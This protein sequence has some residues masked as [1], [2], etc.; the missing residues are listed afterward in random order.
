M[1]SSLLDTATTLVAIL[2]AENTALAALDLSR[3]AQL[4]GAKPEAT[5][6]FTIAHARLS[7]AGPPDDAARNALVPLATQLS[8]LATENHRL[9]DRA[10]DTQRR[11]LDIIAGAVPRASAQAPRYSASGALVGRTRA[12]PVAIAASA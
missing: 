7:A 4:V 11:V 5:D 3:T 1:T 9:L 10:L 6:A 8:A 2:T 12:L